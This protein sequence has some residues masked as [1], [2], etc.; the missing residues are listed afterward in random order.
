MADLFPIFDLDGTLLD[1]DDALV[2]PFLALGIERSAIRFGP[3]VAEECAR[4]GI[5]LDHYVNAYDPALAS[6][7]PGVS[8]VLAGLGRWALCSNKH[9]VP[10]HLELIRYGWTPEVALF[11]DA[12][13]GRPKRLDPVLAQLGLD[14]GEVLFIGDTA[15]DRS[16]AAAVGCRFALAGWNP[17]VEAEAGDVVLPDP[18]A[19]AA[20]LRAG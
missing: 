2:A 13:A 15:H 14:A 7:F 19:L 3:P 4:L 5:P 11:T 6:P 1:S 17:R 18:S 16:A 12:F 10:G 8:E 20:A 9:Q